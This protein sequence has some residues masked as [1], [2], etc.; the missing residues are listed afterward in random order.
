MK[1]NHALKIGL[2]SVLLGSM[3]GA[4]GAKGENNG[5]ERTP[6]LGWSS[7][8]FLREHPSAANIESQ[9]RALKT[10]G[11]QRLGYQYVNVDDFWYK[12][13]GK[14]GP[15]VDRYG[16]W[17]IDSS[18]FPSHGKTNGIQA[19]A[20][21][22]HSL[23]MKFGIYVTPGISMQA[24][25]RNTL[26]QGTSYTADE[27]AEP[28]MK[29]HNYNCGGMVAI[30]YSKPGAQQFINSWADM[31]AR[32]GVDFVKVDG[33]TDKN[34][35][36]IK[37]WSEAIRQSGRKMVLDVTEG[38]FTTAIAPTLMKFANQWEF[39]PDIE[40]YSCEK[41]GSSYPLTDWANVYKRF[42]LVA[43]WWRYAGHGGFNDYDSIE[44]GNGVED[45]LTPDERKVQLSLWA[46]GSAP[47]ILGVD[48]T[49]LN[50]GDLKD[51][52]NREV[53]S[54]D[55][56][57]VA[58]R[59]IVNTRD[60]QV[61]FKVEPNGER[62]VGLFNTSGRSERISIPISAIG[63]AVR[64]DGYSMQNLWTNERAVIRRDISSEVPS[65]G[66]ALFRIREK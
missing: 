35:P 48:V 53:L 44:V 27:I 3:C 66:V 33:M 29:E 1:M 43:K 62:V 12:C 10:S 25:S 5:V 28:G 24:V 54:V 42:D 40:C 60:K 59:R 55:Q 2:V 41:H 15:D 6:V 21:F 46:L 30:D 13:P 34:V 36:D 32:W 18:R 7:W 20:K 65:H 26:I 63:L 61:F 45:G 37:A 16:R 39:A 58:A 17:V 11:L 8:S 14:Q 56:D 9:A 57:G 4:P 23:G 51:L 52:G 49:H 31:F 38:N 19:V 50:A 64:A 47:L 22:V